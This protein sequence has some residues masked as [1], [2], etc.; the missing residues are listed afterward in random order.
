[1]NIAKAFKE[2]FEA[3]F[4]QESDQSKVY[5]QNCE[6]LS[7]FV[8]YVPVELDLLES[9]LNASQFF[10]FYQSLNDLKFLIEFSDDLNRYWYVMRAYSGALFRL[11]SDFSV[12]AAKRLYCYYFDRYGDRR[13]LRN[14]HWFEC[15]RW[16]FL[17]EL[18]LTNTDDELDAFI[19]K[20]KHLLSE[21]FQLYSSFL[22][23]FIYDLKKLQ[24]GPAMLAEC[25][26]P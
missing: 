2:Y 8:L 9:Y 26:R 19:F 3:S 6:F 21:D 14:E 15:K 7:D 24:K 12:K 1:M 11:K 16:E 13:F 23:G 20:Y 25:V 10:L 17:D 22:M 18:L 4:G 5:R